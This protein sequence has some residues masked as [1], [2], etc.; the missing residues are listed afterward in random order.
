VKADAE[1]QGARKLLAF[2]HIEKAAGTSLT[3]ILR[4]VYFLRYADVRPMHSRRQYFFTAHDLSTAIRINPFLLGIGGHSI[5]PH[6][7]LMHSAVVLHFIT[8]LR[9]PV[10]RATSQY[11]YWVN[12]HIDESGPDAYLSHR[13]SK[14]FQVRKIAGCEDLDLA[15]K[16]IEQH[17]LLVG[18]ADRFDEF[19]VLLAAK[20]KMP[21]HLFTYRRKNVDPSPER[22]PVPAYFKD[23]L[24]QRNELDRR[25]YAWVSGDL[26]S[27]YVAEYP[28]DFQSDV[29]RF[30]ALQSAAPQYSLKP[31]IDW[32][33]RKACLEP[34]SGLIRVSNGLPYRGSYAPG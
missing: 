24:Q 1:R 13:A 8:Q 27:R 7:D 12:R 5:V 21:L 26:Y 34:I 14:N 9:D 33:Y 29:A 3:H 4:R 30:R 25:L 22:L 32:L 16:K 18:T 19:L 15:K 31:P 6:G 10:A 2:C 23:V 17:F 20:L 11:R 28:G